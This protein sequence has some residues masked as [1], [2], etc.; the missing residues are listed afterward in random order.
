[1]ETNELIDQAKAK[2]GSYRAVA[3][4]LGVHETM[5]SMVRA[6]QRPLPAFHQAKLAELLEMNP[7][8]AYVEA[9]IRAAAGKTEAAT[10][11]R[12]FSKVAA[13]IAAVFVAAGASGLWPQTSMASSNPEGNSSD[14]YRTKAFIFSASNV[15]R[16]ARRKG[17]L[18]AWLRSQLLF[19]ARAT[20]LQTLADVPALQLS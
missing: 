13:I 2:L 18:R 10:L 1:M 9:Q 5:I 16:A 7:A 17:R 14:A 6:Q 3:K 20:G 19:V 11:K 4:Y 8:Q 12:W 15:R